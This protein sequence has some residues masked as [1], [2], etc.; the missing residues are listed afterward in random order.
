MYVVY[1]NYLMEF[2]TPEFRTI[3]GCVS[4]WSV[5]EMMLALGA[6]FIPEWRQLSWLIS[7]PA[8]FILTAYP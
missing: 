8:L 7:L 5:G 1:V 2:L 6:W 4:L 3:C